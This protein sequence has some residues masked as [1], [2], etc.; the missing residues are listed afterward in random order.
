MVREMPATIIYC[1]HPGW[2]ISCGRD[3]FDGFQE[4]AQAVWG[5]DWGAK[6]TNIDP[7]Q[8]QLFATR[9]Q[10]LIALEKQFDDAPSSALADLL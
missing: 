7:I 3:I 5:E 10:A 6:A 4:D 2:K 1:M 9:S 8:K